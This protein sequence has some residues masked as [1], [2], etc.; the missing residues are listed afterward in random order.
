MRGRLRKRADFRRLYLWHVSAVASSCHYSAA[1]CD[2]PVPAQENIEEFTLCPLT[3]KLTSTSC[4]LLKTGKHTVTAITRSKSEAT[5]P[6]QARVA[7][8]DF[9]DD[10][11]SLAAA[12]HEQDFFVITLGVAGVSAA[13]DNHTKIVYAAARVGACTAD[14]RSLR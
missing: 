14:S 9:H 2:A 1:C 12:L 10:G 3:G 11:A 5:F 7:Q 8:V 6:A 4:L 13:Q